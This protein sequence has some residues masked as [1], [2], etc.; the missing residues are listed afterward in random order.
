VP[1][2]DSSLPVST[3]PNK[4]IAVQETKSE[5]VLNLIGTEYYSAFSIIS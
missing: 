1:M 3:F 4:V 5:K 2:I